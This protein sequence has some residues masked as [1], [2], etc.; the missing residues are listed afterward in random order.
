[1]NFDARKH[2]LEYDDVISKHRNRI[3]NEREKV[4]NLDYNKLE[5]MIL[6]I[7]KA[8]YRHRKNGNGNGKW[9]GIE[10]RESCVV[11]T[12]QIEQVLSTVDE[13]KEDVKTIK[14]VNIPNIVASHSLNTQNIKV[15]STQLKWVLRKLDMPYP[16][17]GS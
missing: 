14:D 8:T 11:H 12:V 5:E 15:N 6:D 2:I 9:G 16:N 4:L 3:Y 1:M 17:N 13:I 7:I 10:R